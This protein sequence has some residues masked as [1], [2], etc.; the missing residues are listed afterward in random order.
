MRIKQHLLQISDLERRCIQCLARIGGLC[1]ALQKGGQQGLRVQRKRWHRP[2]AHVVLLRN[3]G[4]RA[5]PIDR[6]AQYTGT[7]QLG[8]N[9]ALDIGVGDVGGIGNDAGCGICLGNK[10]VQRLQLRRRIFAFTLQV[11][12]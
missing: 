5:Y 4:L 3:I 12:E 9:L 6:I 2:G 7:G 1:I 10:I 8:Q 11:V